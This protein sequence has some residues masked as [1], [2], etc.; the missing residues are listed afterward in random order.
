MRNM[1]TNN[2][3]IIFFDNMCVVCDIFISMISKIDS[4]NIFL[5]A[6]VK[7]KIAQETIPLHIREIDSIILLYQGEYFTYSSAIIKII[8]LQGGLWNILSIAYIIPKP[9]RDFFYKLFAKHRKKIGT[10][11]HTMKHVSLYLEGKMLH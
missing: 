10:S 11:K 3:S 7:G 4:K 1:N 6:P 9:I 5:F 2:N 8:L